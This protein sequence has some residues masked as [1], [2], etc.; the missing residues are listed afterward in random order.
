MLRELL[1]QVEDKK[2]LADH[3]ATLASANEKQTAAIRSELEKAIRQ[4]LVAQANKG[5][6]IR[7]AA[8]F[9]LWLFTL[10]AGAALGTYFPDIVTFFKTLVV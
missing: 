7:Q 6:R 3:Y 2:K 10:V 1:A 4:E 5:R 9:A 8:S